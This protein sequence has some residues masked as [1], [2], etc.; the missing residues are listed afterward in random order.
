MEGDRI[1]DKKRLLVI[2][3]IVIVIGLA[4]LLWGLNQMDEYE[5][6]RVLDEEYQQ[7]YEMG[8]TGVIAGVIILFVGSIISL[9]SLV[10]KTVKPVTI[11]SE[12][13]K[14]ILKE[15]KKVADKPMTKNED[16]I[17]A[18]LRELKDEKKLKTDEEFLELA[19][20]LKDKL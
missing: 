16:E 14:E 10:K 3:A 15:I 2:G 19:K 4:V 20:K 1:T 9:G 11:A 13:E 5:W 6:I 17:L 8:A 7:R 18:I 12:D